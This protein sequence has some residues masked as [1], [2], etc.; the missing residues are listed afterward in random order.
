MRLYWQTRFVWYAGGLG[1]TWWVDGN[2]PYGF[3]SLELGLFS[4]TLQINR[5]A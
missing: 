5:K 4:L 1:V 2:F 3:Y